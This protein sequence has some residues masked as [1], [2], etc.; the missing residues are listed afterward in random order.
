MKIVPFD[1]GNVAYAVQLG[2]ELIEAGTF[3]LNGPPFEWDYALA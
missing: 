1:E 2:R 3:G